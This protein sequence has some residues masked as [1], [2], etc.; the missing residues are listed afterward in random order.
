MTEVAQTTTVPI[1]ARERGPGPGRYRL[2]ST[3]GYEKHDYTK[4]MQPSYTF[5]G[6]LK[7]YNSECSPGPVY[8]VNSRVT[9]HGT[10][11]TPSYSMLGRQ[12]EPA[13]FLT[14]S[15]GAYKPE[16]VH[17]QGERHA[18]VFSMA[19]RTR[20]RK[21]DQN[22][23]PN[24]YVLPKMLG[25]FQPNKLSYPSYSMSLRTNVG[26]YAEDLS[27]TPG[28]GQY[29]AVEPDK[30]RT[31]NAQYSLQGRSYMPGD[32]T[33]KPGPGAHKPEAVRINKPQAPTYSLGIRHSEYVSP[34][35]INLD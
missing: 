34:L 14:P 35:L 12:R 7:A 16:R 22:P 6:R 4:Y 9:R 11:G 5:G 13:S 18:P 21:R 28:P 10:D 33:R 3:C 25:S 8:F 23:A 24:R 17:P 19:T 2:P 20:I 1:A 29:N 32:N 31:R 27:K 30:I 15:P 26:S